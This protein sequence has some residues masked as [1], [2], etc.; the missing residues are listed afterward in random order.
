[1]PVLA[2][3]PSTWPPDLFDSEIRPGDTGHWYVYYVRARMEKAVARRLRIRGISYFLP[4][5]ESRKRYQRRLVCS[6]LPLFP[7]YV[8]VVGDEIASERL[9]DLK[10]VV[11][12]LK[13]DDQP[14]IDRELRNIHVALRSGQCVTREER[15]EP[16][17]QARIV[18]GP[19]AGLCGEV[20]KNRHGLRFILRI[21][22][23]QQGVW[24]EADGSMIEAI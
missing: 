3:E 10:E 7:G 1:M 9:T 11:S 6:H 8:F 19:L 13:V 12:S 21:Q 2:L 15:L 18:S 24:L 23:L 5:R 22:F 20:I 17:A 4:M 14:Q 16:G